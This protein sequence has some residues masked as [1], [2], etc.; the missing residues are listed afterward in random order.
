VR[1]VLAESLILA[2]L[3]GAAGIPLAMVGLGL[4]KAFGPQDIP[5]IDRVGLDVTA[6]AFTIGLSAVTGL[7]FG[8]IPAFRGSRAE[9]SLALNDARLAADGGQRR[10][11]HAALAAQMT[12]A[13]FVLIAA[14]L[15]LRSLDR[16]LAVD[17]GFDGDRVLVA[18][19]SLPDAKYGTV[20]K[21]T[22]F[23]D[24]LLKRVRTTP[25]IHAAGLMSHVPLGGRPL[26]SDFT[27]AGR[28]AGASSE[29][30]WADCAAIAGD[31]F[32]AVGMRVLRGRGFSDDDRRNRPAVVIIND[33]M[34]RRFWADGNAIGQH[35]VLGA[36]MGA[37]REPREIVGIV[38]DVRSVGVEVA[39]PFQVYVPYAQTGWPTM[40]L[41]VRSD[42]DPVRVAAPIRAAVAAL[43]PD[44]AIYGVRP[45]SQILD[46]ANAPRRFQTVVVAVFAV[47][48]LLLAMT[49]IYSVVTYTVRQRAKETA[50]RV[51]LGA[52]AR[53]VLVLMTGET[54]IWATS[55]VALGA[56]LA[57][58]AGR[59]F[60]GVLYGV[61]P[62]DPLTFLLVLGST[63]ALAAAGSLL[64]GW[65]AVRV[66]PLVSLRRS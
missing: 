30:R 44:Q 22:A 23:F 35:I 13:A 48:G 8:L 10:L 25:G 26:T 16:V 59:A 33:T 43:D 2:C 52:Q 40:S 57:L 17:V 34:A 28:P 1:R 4:F 64:A 45:L 29:T 19:A 60:R 58:L 46:R 6:L 63:T 56:I 54:L 9:L 41:A 14:G 24:D 21:R 50:V 62:A 3:G 37:A 51:A 18:T 31:L 27:I 55:G 53:D 65:R 7:V 11:R 12:L 15:L 61:T 32:D 20:E 38:S 49:G 5:R 42:G 36:G 66:D 47:L 39:P